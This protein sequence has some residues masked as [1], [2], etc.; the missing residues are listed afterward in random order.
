MRKDGRTDMAKLTVAFRNFVNAPKI[1]IMLYR[2]WKTGDAAMV[3]GCHIRKDDD[4][5]L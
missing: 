4:R 5:K 3:R 2:T 1:G